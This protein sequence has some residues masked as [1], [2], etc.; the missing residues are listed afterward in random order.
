MYALLN[1]LL[2]SP[3]D[4]ITHQLNVHADRQVWV[5]EFIVNN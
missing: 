2:D 5:M 1:L 3:G 4:K